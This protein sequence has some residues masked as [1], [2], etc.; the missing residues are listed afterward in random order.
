LCVWGKNESNK[1]AKTEKKTTAKSEV[2]EKAH[3]QGKHSKRSPQALSLVQLKDV[4][5]TLRAAMLENILL[6]AIVNINLHPQ[7]VVMKHSQLASLIKQNK[8]VNN[9]FIFLGFKELKVK[10]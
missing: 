2:T 4:V 7:L 5:T 9:I 8:L 1:K 3:N 10:Q 6:M